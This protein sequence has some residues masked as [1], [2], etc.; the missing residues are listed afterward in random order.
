MTDKIR[1]QDEQMRDNHRLA[2]SNITDA[3]KKR[4]MEEKFAAEERKRERENRDQEKNAKKLLEDAKA[5]L[6]ASTRA[7]EEARQRREVIIHA[8]P[9]YIYHRPPW[10]PNYYWPW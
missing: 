6:E 4:E 8:P 9:P 3:N 7:L 2:L 5:R 10:H 1:L